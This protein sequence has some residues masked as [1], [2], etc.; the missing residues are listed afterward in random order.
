ML[1]KNNNGKSLKEIEKDKFER[2]MQIVAQKAGYYRE[3]PHRFVSEV[4]FEPTQFA[5]VWFQ[6]IIL[7]AM[8]HNN[9]VMYYAA[10]G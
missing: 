4:L 10:R 8:F 1:S 7:W 3:N 2:L 9:Y 5:L 6:A